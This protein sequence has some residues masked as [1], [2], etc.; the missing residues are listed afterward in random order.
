MKAALAHIGLGSNVGDSAGFVREAF[1][2][3]ERV[4]KITAIS[5]LYLT[6]PWGVVDQAPFVNAVAAVKTTL[7][8]PDLVNALLAIEREFGRTR[9]ERYGPRTLDLDLLLYGDLTIDE[10]GCT[11]PHPQLHRRA[12][13][14]V[15]LAQ[16]A[17]GV[18]VPPT[19]KMVGEL[20]AAVPPADR[21]DVRQLH[22]T[23]HLPPA[24]YVD[25]DEPGGAG[26]EYAQLR[27]FSAFD[28]S[29]L[30]AVLTAIGPI[31]RRRVLDVG[32]G[33]GRFT[34]E[35][36]SRGARVTGIDRSETM[37][38]EA[39]ATPSASSGTPPEYVRGDAN[40]ALPGSNFNAITVFYALQYLRV[41]IFCR[42]AAA[43]LAPG[44]TLAIASFPHRHF[45]ESEFARFFPSMVAF[46]LARFPSRQ[47]L[48]AD[49]VRAGFAS[50]RAA[51]IEREMHDRAE[52]VVD[53]VERK[54]LSSFHLLPDDEFRRGLAAMRKAWLPGEDVH[55]TAHAMVVWGTR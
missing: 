50:V 32:C 30:A 13:V 5:D 8:A 6:A 15:P 4:G 43:A 47:Q 24:P 16:I 12:F 17:A 37:L 45:A 7:P 21:A 51:M 48:E 3:L 55:R 53:K 44:G 33:T 41:P 11:V 39:R 38:N 2:A 29:V 34:R 42:V 14:L 18:H 54:Y 26:G 27:P 19:G 20:L 31:E 22:G 28:E 9:G 46:D 52:V 35:L 10:P 25:Y 36:A 1:T 40:V 23:A 49:F